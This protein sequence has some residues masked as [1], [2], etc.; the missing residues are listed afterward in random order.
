[1]VELLRDRGAIDGQAAAFVC[2]NFACE[3]PVTDA[4]S[5]RNLL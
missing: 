1:V 5:L 3:L 4:A 2:E